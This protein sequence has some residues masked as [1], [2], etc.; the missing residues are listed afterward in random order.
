MTNEDAAMRAAREH[1]PPD[2]WSWLPALK[3]SA[4]AERQL[5]R[6]VVLGLVQLAMPPQQWGRFVAMTGE[7][8]RRKGVRLHE[9]EGSLAASDPVSRWA[10]SLPRV[11]DI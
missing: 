4:D 10:E 2:A 11:N 6:A 1:I 8:I 9:S 3:L 7:L 5:R